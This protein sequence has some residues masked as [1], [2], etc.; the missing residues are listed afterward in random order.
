MIM[1]VWK[2]NAAWFRQAVRSVLD[3][4]D[5]ALELVVVDDGN[6][7]PVQA[8]LQDFDDAR[9]VIVR[10]PHGGVSRA[11]NAGIERAA[12]DA[13]RFVDADDVLEPESTARLLRLVGTEGAIAYGSTLVCDTELKPQRVIEATVEGY[14]LVDCLLGRLDVRMMSMLFPRKVVSA[15]GGFDPAFEVNEDFDYV[16][17]ALDHAPVRGERVIATRYRRHA[18]SIT[19]GPH[20]GK[21]RDMQ[22]LDKLVERRPDLR[23]TRPERVARRH[24]H[25]NAVRQLLLVGQY[26]PAAREIAAAMR[27]DP[28]GS[29]PEVSQI[30]LGLLRRAPR[31]MA[32]LVA[33]SFGGRS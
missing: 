12:G 24:V 20:A 28:V 16:L 7:E 4:R 6:E 22:A 13:I 26:R 8:L 2:P 10:F 27:L 15:V 11:R 19:A 30:V 29:A 9:L 14:A 33:G 21:K 1:P 23:G 31:R 17:R 25:L 3:Q 18:G 5:C 32:R